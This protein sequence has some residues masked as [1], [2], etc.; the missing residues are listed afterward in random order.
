MVHHIKER[1]REFLERRYQLDGSQTDH[2]FPDTLLLEGMFMIYTISLPNSTMLNYGDFLLTRYTTYYLHR[3]VQDIHIIFNHPGRLA[4]HPK[5][6]ERNQRDKQLTSHTHT[7]FSDTQK[8][9]KKWN[10]LLQ[11]RECKRNLVTYLG[12]CFLCQAP[13]LLQGNQKMYASGSNEGAK[14]D[15]AYY[16]TAS[17]TQNEEPKLESNAEEADTRVWLHV[18]KSSGKRVLIYSPDND[19]LHIGLLVAN[20][21]LKD[22]RIQTSRS[23]HYCSRRTYQGDGV[24]VHPPHSLQ[25]TVRQHSYKPSS[26]MLTSYLVKTLTLTYLAHLLMYMMKYVFCLIFDW[27]VLCT[28]R[29]FALL[30]RSTTHPQQCFTLLQKKGSRRS[31]C[32][33]TGSTHFGIK[34]GSEWFSKI[35]SF[36][37]LMLCIVTF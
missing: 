37:L 12:D 16:A 7:T 23:S 31:K 35:T 17:T 11:C 27:L 22:I 9:P 32:I 34:Y 21:I 3:G 1:R 28:I 6:I 36:H 33:L 14:A 30:S 26:S 18:V 5:C 2:W 10:E 25:D 13:A 8:V 19:V 15:K 24:I 4:D 20:T 29:S